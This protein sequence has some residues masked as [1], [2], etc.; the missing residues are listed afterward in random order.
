MF[1]HFVFFLLVFSILLRVR[2][3]IFVYISCGLFLHSCV[4][5]YLQDSAV[6]CRC[7][8]LRE[9]KQHLAKHSTEVKKP[10]LYILCHFW[11]VVSEMWSIRTREKKQHLSDRKWRTD[12]PG[13][14]LH[15]QRCA[16]CPCCY[17]FEELVSSGFCSHTATVQ[18]MCQC[19]PPLFF[20]TH[21]ILTPDG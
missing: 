15:K 13:V 3:C 6:V 19:S 7:L 16:L 9:C 12:N 14:C 21:A 2:R 20:S 8:R 18:G 1:P 4:C 17:L 11:A 10:Q 5:L